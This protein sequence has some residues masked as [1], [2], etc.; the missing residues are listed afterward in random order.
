MEGVVVIGA[1]NKPDML[2]PAL[3]RPGR[4]DRLLLTP[5]PDKKSRIAIFAIHTKGMPLADD[6]SLE[7]LAEETE[8]FS[9]ADIEGLC[10]EAA[11]LALREDIKAGE[12]NKTHFE[13]AK[14]DVPASITKDLIN[15]Y[16]RLN[17]GRS[18]D[19]LKEY[20]RDTDV[21]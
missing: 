3:L 2:D 19:I 5:A 18:S 13:R 10:R 16:K 15:Y 12:V 4:F 7:D 9:G 6:I 21:A 20:K 14:K 11:M 17:E 1:T 8:G